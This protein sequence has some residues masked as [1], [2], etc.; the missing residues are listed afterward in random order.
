M[1]YGTLLKFGTGFNRKIIFEKGFKKNMIAN[2]HEHKHHVLN[3][4][5]IS[6]KYFNKG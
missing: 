4:W 1:S 2:Y 3:N 6:L 5:A